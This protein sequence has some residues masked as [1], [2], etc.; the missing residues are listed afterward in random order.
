MKVF[1]HNDLDGRCAAAVVYWLS[2]E[3]KRDD[4]ELWNKYFKD[5]DLEYRG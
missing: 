2:D 4:I 1:Y 3:K 5:Y